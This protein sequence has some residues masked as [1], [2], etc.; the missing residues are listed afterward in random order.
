MKKGEWFRIVRAALAVAVLLLWCSNSALAE[1][2]FVDNGD[3][4]VTDT[5]T[6]LMWAKY[7]CQG[8]INWHQAKDYCTYVLLSH[9]HD[10]RMPTIE[11]LETLYNPNEEGYETACG[12]IVKVNPAIR[13]SCGWVWAADV[14]TISAFAYCFTRGYR[15]TDRMVHKRHYRA[16]PVRTIK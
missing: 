5:K 15:Y 11:E 12:D 13:L 14:R 9:Y 10:W 3:G 1:G 6:N 7:D 16:L 8:D 4:T 2:R